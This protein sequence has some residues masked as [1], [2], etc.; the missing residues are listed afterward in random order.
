MREHSWIH[1]FVVAAAILSLAVVMTIVAGTP[2]A[3]VPAF[4]RM[5]GVP[6]R[7][8]HTVAPALNSTGQAFQANFF[9][10]TSESGG[11]IPKKRGLL[12]APISGIVTADYIRNTTFK[13]TS[14]FRFENLELYASDSFVLDARRNGG[15][16]VD[17]VVA[18]REG[19]AGDLNNAWA[20]VPIYGKRGEVAVTAGQFSPMMYQYDSMNSLTVALPMGLSQGVDGI[21][22]TAPTPGIRLDY[23]NNRVKGTADGDYLALGLPFE[24][25]LTLNSNSR[26]YDA[27]G[28]FVHGFRRQAKTSIGAF[29]YL[30]GDLH[31]IG[32]LGTYTALPE[33]NL[34]AAYAD[35]H[36]RFGKNRGLSLEANWAPKPVV[37][38]TGRLESISGFQKDTYPVAAVTYYPFSPP[39]L[40]LSVE[41]I[42]QKGNRQVAMYVYGLF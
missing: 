5:Y 1:R 35:S 41:T 32:L 21:A 8:C 36:D 11:V 38:L 33:L 24:G 16:F 25:H 42:Q 26:L 10:W 9:H 7:T 31:Q 34:L 30:N 37:A 15:Y 22:F 4:S 17:F 13:I 2:A 40:R 20:A 39:F 3:A 19:R 23:F 6:C 27:R 28:L 18:I 12:A 29:G 14:D